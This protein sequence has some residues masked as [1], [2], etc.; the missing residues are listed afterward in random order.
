M[1]E[2]SIK[3]INR[4]IGKR[5]QEFRE[6]KKMKQVDMSGVFRISVSAYSKIETGVN[7][8]TAKHLLTLYREFRLSADWLLIGE[9]AKETKAFG[10]NEEDVKNMLSDM[11]DNKMVLHSI[12][13][14][15][16]GLIDMVKKRESLKLMKD[17]NP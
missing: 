7:E 15:Y 10:N 12:L 5:L 6:S 17:N 16:Y 9:S 13:S 4:K 11:T 3:L 8:L 14:H 2:E 1:K